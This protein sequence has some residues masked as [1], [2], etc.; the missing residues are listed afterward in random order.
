MYVSILIFIGLFTTTLLTHSRYQSIQSKAAYT[1][2]DAV[3]GDD[4]IIPRV[5]FALSTLIFDSAFPEIAEI[6][7]NVLL[8]ACMY[9]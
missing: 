3:I 2:F 4:A 8:Q 6:G 9:A 1:P 7:L 5:M